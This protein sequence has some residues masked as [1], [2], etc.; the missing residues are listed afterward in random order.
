MG[1]FCDQPMRKA[2]HCSQPKSDELLALDDT[3]RASRQLNIVWPSFFAVCDADVLLNHI[4][5]CNRV[6]PQ[7]QLEPSRRLLLWEHTPTY[8]NHYWSQPMIP[9]PEIA[10]AFQLTPHNASGWQQRISG[11]FIQKCV[12]HDFPFFPYDD[13]VELAMNYTQWK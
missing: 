2:T 4:T 11:G 12:T 1:N 3:F 7:R 6:H 8:R 5:F 13:Q 9:S 10:I